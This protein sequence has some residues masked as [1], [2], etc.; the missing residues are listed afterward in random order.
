MIPRGSLG[1]D[2]QNDGR[3]PSSCPTQINAD[4]IVWP[5]SPFFFVFFVFFALAARPPPRDDVGGR[6]TKLNI[7]SLVRETRL[8]SHSVD[9][10]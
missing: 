7:A 8:S 9:V 4:F 10:D 1:L 6:A 3:P 5:P 2:G